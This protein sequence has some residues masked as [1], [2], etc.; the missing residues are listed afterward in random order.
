MP[1]SRRS[2]SSSLLDFRCTRPIPLAHH[3]S[4]EDKL[5]LAAVPANGLSGSHQQPLSVVTT[6]SNLVGVTQPFRLAT[7]CETGWVV[8]AAG[9]ASRART[10][11][12]RLLTPRCI[13]IDLT[14]NFTV[15]TV[16]TSRK[17]ISS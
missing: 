2:G 8:Q 5:A 13:Y 12:I 11:A 10:A 7:T 9:L 16:M 17:L 4:G 1:G 3:G 15:L 14:W 6:Q